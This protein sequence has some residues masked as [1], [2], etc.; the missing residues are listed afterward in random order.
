[1]K[2]ISQQSIRHLN[3]VFL[4]I[5]GIAEFIP[6]HFSFGT[7]A[8]FYINPHILSLLS[9]L[10]LIYLYSKTRH[11]LIFTYGLIIFMA[12]LLRFNI[13]LRCNYIIAKFNS[14]NAN[15][16]PIF[17][18]VKEQNGNHGRTFEWKSLMQNQHVLVNCVDHSY[19][20]DVVEREII[21]VIDSDWYINYTR[22]FE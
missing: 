1:M 12:I 19:H 5:L 3:G 21:E 13:R 17:L 11:I 20:S 10:G 9:C 14:K 18:G 6:I 22:P 4:L 15:V 16:G 7:K 8:L 2:R